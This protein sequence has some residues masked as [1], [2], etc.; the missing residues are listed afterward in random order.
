MDITQVVKVAVIFWQMYLNV[1][2]Y[3]RLHKCIKRFQLNV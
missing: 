2:I 1:G 3:M